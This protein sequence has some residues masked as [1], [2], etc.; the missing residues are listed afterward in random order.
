[1]PYHWFKNKCKTVRIII[2]IKLWVQTILVQ[3]DYI[4]TTTKILCTKITTI[5]QVSRCKYYTSSL[6]QF[7]FQ[8]LKQDQKAWYYWLKNKM[9]IILKDP[10]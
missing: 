10:K 8:S 5:S 6:R 7:E 9:K 3:I 4:K 2:C 1:M